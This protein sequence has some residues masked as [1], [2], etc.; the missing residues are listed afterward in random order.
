MSS[1]QT[2]S[3]YIRSADDF[4]D[5]TLEEV[6][7]LTDDQAEGMS[8]GWEER[9]LD[10]DTLFPVVSVREYYNHYG[11]DYGETYD[12][13]KRTGRIIIR[14]LN[15]QYDEEEDEWLEGSLAGPLGGF[16]L[17][18]SGNRLEQGPFF[19]IL[20]EEDQWGTWYY[21]KL[22]DGKFVTFAQAWAGQDKSF[23]R[24]LGEALIEF[25]EKCEPDK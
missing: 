9:Q 20:A 16:Y 17:E 25:A 10:D 14:D 18:A 19:S 23:I 8:D 21:L 6:E 13:E 7:A 24:Q 22:G 2:I 4:R 15:G 5:M 1:H 11:Q 3:V 12:A